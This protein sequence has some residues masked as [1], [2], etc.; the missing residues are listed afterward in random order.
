MKHCII[1]DTS[2]I[3]ATIDSNDSFHADA[4]NTFREL[5]SRKSRIKIVIPPL[6]IY[7]TIIALTRKGVSHWF[8]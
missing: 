5:I 4:V 2:F 7:E 3:V 6:A 1:E 8:R